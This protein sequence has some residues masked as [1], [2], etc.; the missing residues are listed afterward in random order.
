MSKQTTKKSMHAKTYTGS[1]ALCCFSLQHASLL[2]ELHMRPRRAYI[3]SHAPTCASAGPY[4]G[5][6]AIHKILGHVGAVHPPRLRDGE[7]GQNNQKGYVRYSP[8]RSASNAVSTQCGIP[9]DTWRCPHPRRSTDTLYCYSMHNSAE[10][11]AAGLCPSSLPLFTPQKTCQGEHELTF[12]L[13]CASVIAS[14]SFVSSEWSE[15]PR[16]QW[17]PAAP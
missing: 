4:H 17:S 12:A 9:H 3:H 2:L 10:R 7:S 11:A 8:R 14:V 13:Y 6:Y 5:R 15:P 1:F 16:R